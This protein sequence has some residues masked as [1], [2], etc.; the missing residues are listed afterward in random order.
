M[1]HFTLLHYE[2]SI[3]CNTVIMKR[4]IFKVFNL[5]FGSLIRGIQMTLV[6][7]IPIQGLHD[8]VTQKAIQDAAEYVVSNFSR[9]MVFNTREELWGYCISRNPRL[10]V[11]GG[12]S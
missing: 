1:E 3:L 5:T 12:D 10:Q 6:N 11:G 2:L 9:A 7:R 8:Q 4:I